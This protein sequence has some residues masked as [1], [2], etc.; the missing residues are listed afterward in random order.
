MVRKSFE[1]FIKTEALDYYSDKDK[2][3]NMIH[4]NDCITLMKQIRGATLEEAAN[5]ANADFD[6]IRIN[7]CPL[8]NIIEVYVLKNSI[9]DLDKNSIEL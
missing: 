3:L 6:I 9:L 1:E 8:D 5:K 4:I 2:E 7:D